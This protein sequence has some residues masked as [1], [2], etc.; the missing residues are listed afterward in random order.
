[1]GKVKQA[2]LWLLVMGVLVLCVTSLQEHGAC[3]NFG[4]A[5]CRSWCW[6]WHDSLP[7][8][9]QWV[10]GLGFLFAPLVLLAWFCGNGSSNTPHP[11]GP[12]SDAHERL[13]PWMFIVLFSPGVFIALWVFGLVT[14]PYYPNWR[15]G[16]PLTII[17][18]YYT[19]EQRRFALEHEKDPVKWGDSYRRSIK[20]RQDLFQR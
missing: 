20:G 15:Q 1:M 19:E 14:P 10:I 3:Q 12:Y 18:D 13:I 9:G 17:P 4:C 6:Y 7:Q 5:E 16:M 2:V 11:M 8:K